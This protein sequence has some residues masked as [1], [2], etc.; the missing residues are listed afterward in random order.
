MQIE[1]GVME[2]LPF[3]KIHNRISVVM[4]NKCDV[5]KMISHDETGTRII[6]WETIGKC[7]ERQHAFQEFVPTFS[8]DEIYRFDSIVQICIVRSPVSAQ[9]LFCAGR[10][11]Y[12]RI[13]VLFLLGC[14]LIMSQGLNFEETVLA[15]RPFKDLFTRYHTS[16]LWLQECWRALCCSKCLYWINFSES[17]END[18]RVGIQM[19][20]YIHY[21]RCA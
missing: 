6:C 2:N 13:R 4:G 5:K 8:L 3:V 18:D 14:H 11:P 12:R 9:L 15:F 16:E 19:D 17:Q 21:A 20:E 1:Q 7:Q 10:L